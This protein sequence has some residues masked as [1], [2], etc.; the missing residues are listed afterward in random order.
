MAAKTTLHEANLTE[1]GI[2]I[3]SVLIYLSMLVELACGIN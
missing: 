2:A 1:L 3:C